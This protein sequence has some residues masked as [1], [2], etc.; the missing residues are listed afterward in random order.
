NKLLI[1]KRNNVNYIYRF[2]KKPKEVKEVEAL[3]DVEQD[4]RSASGL[5]SVGVVFSPV[6]STRVRDSL[7]KYGSPTR[8][9]LVENMFG[10]IQ[11]EKTV[12]VVKKETKTETDPEA[13]PETAPT[14]KEEDADEPEEV[15]EE[16]LEEARKIPAAYIWNF[17]SEG[18]SGGGFIIQWNEPYQKRLYTKRLDYFSSELSSIINSDYKK[19]FSA[20]ETKIINDLLSTPPILPTEE[21][22]KTK[23]E[24]T[25]PPEKTEPTNP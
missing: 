24:T 4:H 13:K 25:I 20:R 15:E 12:K 6:E 17:E 1:V 19:Y 5:F 8:E 2:Y 14:K 3:K 10:I 23:T 7:K 11:E 21:P 18:E 9:Y 16:D 22:T